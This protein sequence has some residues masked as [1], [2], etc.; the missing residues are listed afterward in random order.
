MKIALHELDYSFNPS[1]HTASLEPCP[2]NRLLGF[3]PPLGEAN[4][5]PSNC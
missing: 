1:I 5:E 3:L 2:E 4:F